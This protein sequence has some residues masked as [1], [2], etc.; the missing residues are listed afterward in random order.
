VHDSQSQ[1]LDRTVA[2]NLS[3]V[4]IGFGSA[5]S[6]VVLVIK[7]VDTEELVYTLD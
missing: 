4:H 5:T 7:L 6:N 2:L 1:N 3:L